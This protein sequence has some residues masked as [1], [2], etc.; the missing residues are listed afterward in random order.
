MRSRRRLPVPLATLTLAFGLAAPAPAQ[1][2]VSLDVTY[3]GC[4]TVSGPLS[5]GLASLPASIDAH[6]VF[7]AP[8]FPPPNDDVAFS[9]ELLSASMSVGD[10]SLVTAD[11]ASFSVAFDFDIDT[12]GT[13]VSQLTWSTIPRG[14]VTVSN[15]ESLNSDF[16]LNLTGTDDASGQDF[17]YRCPNSSQ[18]FAE[19]AAASGAYEVVGDTDG[20]GW[21]FRLEALDA[22]CQVIDVAEGSSTG[23]PATGDPVTGALVFTAAMQ[24]LVNA[25]GSDFVAPTTGTNVL[26]IYHP[27]ATEFWLLGG[28]LT[29]ALT[30]VFGLT[31]LNPT[32]ERIEG[33][34]SCP[35]PEIDVKP[36]SDVNSINPM[37]RGVVSVAILGSEGFDVL[38]VDTSTLSFGPRGAG[39]AA[40]THGI[41]GHPEDVDGDGL[42]DLVS[43][44][45]VQQTGIAFGETEACVKG[46]LLDGRSFEGC[47]T[48]R[49]VAELGKSAPQPAPLIGDLPDDLPGH[50]RA[51]PIGGIGDLGCVLGSVR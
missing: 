33:T 2:P 13:E 41:G 15:L 49:T 29:G 3:S 26:D 42:T 39:G 46:E 5:L 37:G 7:L 14:T 23:I 11:W 12:Q 25:A 48:I 6:F 34:S 9:P 45:G 40:P 1:V 17:H 28:D 44:Y 21:R 51:A 20:S 18:S 43:H 38:D 16:E 8:S 19:A 22:S 47:D 36:G 31:S 4:T 35:A 10:A 27:T 30:R 24:D 32:I 50:G